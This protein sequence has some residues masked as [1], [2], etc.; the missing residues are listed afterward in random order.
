MAK[1]PKQGAVDSEIIITKPDDWHLHVRDGAVLEAVL[2]DTARH[3]GRAII[4][5]N[6][7]APVVTAADAAAYRG[8]IMAALPAG[9]DFT[10]LMTAYLTEGTV[11]EDIVAGHADGIIT[12]VKLYPAGATTNSSSGVRS[13]KSV[14]GVLEAMAAARIPLLIHGEVTDPE[15]DLFDFEKVFIERVLD[16]L[17]DDLP[18]LPIVL[19][20]ITT[21]D[22]VSYVG[23]QETNLAATITPPHLMLER[24]HL[25]AG[26]IR[27]HF[28]C[29]PI[30]KGGEH[31][32]ALLRA[33]TSGDR[34]FFLGTDS[35]P[36][37][38]SAKLRP[39]GSAGI[40]SAPVALSCYAEVFEREGALDK[41]EN[42]A[43]LNGAAYYG[44]P[45]ND[46]K[47][48]LTRR[49]TACQ[50]PEQ[51]KTGEGEITIFAPD[52][53]LFWHFENLD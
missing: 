30:I 8:R 11:P 51:V 14:M 46:S 47:I 45:P 9:M 34:R 10:P 44:L 43:S 21:A 26:G 48:K 20:H 4:M 15:I 7:A 6:L 1:Q 5:P 13:I 40:Y 50:Y 2:P 35:A 16:P 3:F 22:A 18:E 52:A 27:P 12:A 38:D 37:L 36:H 19:E 24:N 25:L 39:C 49:N 32:L 31:R 28:Y 53:E 17:R 29:L 33:A 23:A 41:L 42:F